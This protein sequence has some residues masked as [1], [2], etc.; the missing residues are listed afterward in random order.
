MHFLSWYPALSSHIYTCLPSSVGVP[1]FITPS[2]FPLT[3]FPTK[4]ET[5][6]D[7]I[8]TEN[9]T[10]TIMPVPDDRILLPTHIPGKGAV[11]ESDISLHVGERQT[12]WQ[13]VKRFTKAIGLALAGVI[14]YHA[15]LAF[16]VYIAGNAPSGTYAVSSPEPYVRP[17]FHTSLG[18]PKMKR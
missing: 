18:F 16:W 6:T 14:L 7:I 17:S 4:L 8:L 12:R 9:P 10:R 3:K 15:M 13:T 5:N 2:H 11:D 1:H